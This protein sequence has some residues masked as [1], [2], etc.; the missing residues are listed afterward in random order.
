M[1]LV[2]TILFLLFLL[3]VALLNRQSASEVIKINYN[4]YQL[5]DLSSNTFDE[6]PIKEVVNVKIDYNGRRIYIDGIWHNST[7]FIQK[8]RFA[9][10]YK[11]YYCSDSASHNACSV[12][13]TDSKRDSSL[14]VQYTEF[15]K[16]KFKK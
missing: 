10:G 1:K 8:K 16:I 3:S 11:I 4:S 5:F 12:E 2:A 14:V 6:P 9:G 15:I 7:F 13:L